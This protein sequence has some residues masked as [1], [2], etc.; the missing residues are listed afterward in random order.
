MGP[1]HN[2][3]GRPGRPDHEVK[4]NQLA[5]VTMPQLVGRLRLTDVR[6]S[7][8]QARQCSAGR[9]SRMSLTLGKPGWL[10]AVAGPGAGL[11]T[12]LGN[13]SAGKGRVGPRRRICL[14]GSSR[15]YAGQADAVGKRL[16]RIPGVVGDE[17]LLGDWCC[18]IPVAIGAEQGWGPTA[19]KRLKAKAEASAGVT[20]V[21]VIGVS[22]R[23]LPSSA[24]KESLQRVG[25]FSDGAEAR[26]WCWRRKAVKR[27]R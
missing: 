3:G 27:T 11:G 26:K 4:T 17:E 22:G 7:E 24:V 15:P 23:G 25:G 19:S 18:S 1:A 6:S 9:G 12:Q 13:R 16:H 20:K 8:L 2:W 10:P 5:N 14:S 21:R